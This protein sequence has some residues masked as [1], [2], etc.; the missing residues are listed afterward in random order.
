M[1]GFSF[2][3]L[4]WFFRFGFVWFGLGF[5]GGFVCCFCCGFGFVCCSLFVLV[6]LLVGGFLSSKMLAFSAKIKFFKI[7]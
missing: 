2:D 4:V 6:G 1:W 3:G 7:N 5:F